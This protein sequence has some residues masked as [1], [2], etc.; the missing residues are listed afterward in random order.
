DHELPYGDWLTMV[1]EAFGVPLVVKKGEEP[2]K[3]DFFQDTFLTMCKST[4]ENGVWWIGSG[5]NRRR[6]NEV[7]APKKRQKRKKKEI[8]SNLIGKSSLMRLPLRGNPD[9]E[10]SFMMPRIR[11]KV[12]RR[13][14][15]RFQRTTPQSSRQAEGTRHSQSRPSV[16]TA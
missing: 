2:K 4:R 10:I 5:E 13:F 12:H 1:F 7:E 16:P 11:N 6:D 14:K 9:R 3:Y 15:K 8:R